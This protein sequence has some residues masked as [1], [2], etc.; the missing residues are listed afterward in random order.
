MTVCC[1]NIAKI[2]LLKKWANLQILQQINVKK[3]LSI[4]WCRDSNPRP[5]EHESP[6]ITT[7]PGLPPEF[8]TIYPSVLGLHRQIVVGLSVVRESVP[9]LDAGEFLLEM[10]ICTSRTAYPVR[11]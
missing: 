9:V 2:K 5:L 10:Y 3:C 7:R 8:G 6:S 11:T 1:T 4:I